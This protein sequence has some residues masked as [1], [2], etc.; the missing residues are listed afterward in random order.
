MTCAEVRE[1]LSAWLD[2]ELDL[3]T[4]L[5]IERHLE[6]CPGCSESRDRLVALQAALKDPALLEPLP[7]DLTP[8]VRRALRREVPRA[9]VSAPW[10]LGVAAALAC[11][12]LGGRYLAGVGGAGPVPE[13]VS[14]HVR[15]LLPDHLMDVASSDR[16]TVKPFFHGRLDYAPPVPDLASDGFPLA[17]GRVDV[18]GGRRVAA[19]VYMRRQHVVNVFV[20]PKAGGALPPPRMVDGYAVRGFEAGGF[21]FWAVSDLDPAE[22]GHFAD[23]VRTAVGS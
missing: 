22:L 18:V 15:S 7:P 14:A 9:A 8:R 23:L 12:F 3:R 21:V 6:T 16:H 19:L 2:R 4:S 1:L 5:E 17:G 20:V 13:V 11:A 10:S